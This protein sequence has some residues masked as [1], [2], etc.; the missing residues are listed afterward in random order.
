MKRVTT[1]HRRSLLTSVVGDIHFRIPLA[2]L[3][4]GLLLLKLISR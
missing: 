4:L 1:V 2:A 3:L